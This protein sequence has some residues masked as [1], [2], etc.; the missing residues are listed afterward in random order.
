MPGLS[1]GESREGAKA[2]D[3][4]VWDKYYE[5]KKS[6]GEAITEAE[7][8]ITKLRP[9]ASKIEEHHKNVKIARGVG[10]TV[11]ALAAPVTIGSLIAVP[12]TGGLSL[13]AAAVT[14]GVSG[15]VVA[16]GTA[17][18]AGS[19]IAGKVLSEGL[20]DDADEALKAFQ[21]AD[22]RMRTLYRAF[23]A[24]SDEVYWECP[25]LQ[26][27][28]SKSTFEVVAFIVSVCYEIAGSISMAN[29][30]QKLSKIPGAVNQ[31]F[32]FVTGL[33]TTGL[34][35]FA[36][37]GTIAVTATLIF[38]VYTIVDL[39]LNEP[40]KAAEDVK[41]TIRELEERKEQL[42]SLLSKTTMSEWME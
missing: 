3:S 19:T 27:C 13:I 34:V 16:A 8:A 6:F 11:G 17:T 2:I 38:N 23:T 5:L 14:A 30:L 33:S 15:A 42:E 26:R 32:S 1:W 22:S 28:F 10:A 40:S 31:A 20:I 12:F 39:I 25:Q 4:K 41:N 21:K 18:N 35:V 24:K 37:F 36:V 29:A 9:I 7:N